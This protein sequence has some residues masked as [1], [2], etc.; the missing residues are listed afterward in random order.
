MS[1]MLV[2]LKTKSYSPF[3]HLKNRLRA[4]WIQA[5]NGKADSNSKHEIRIS[6][7]IQMFKFKCLFFVCRF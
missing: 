6:K 4:R 2:N 3:G 5:S 1:P 7:Q